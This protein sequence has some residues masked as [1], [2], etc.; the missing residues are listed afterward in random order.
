MAKANKIDSNVTGLRYAEEVSLGVLPASPVWKPLEPNSYN[1]FGGQITT[2]ARNPINP[3]RQRKKGVVTDLDASGGFNSDLT[4]E[5][6]QDILQ[7]FFFASLRRKGEMEYFTFSKNFVATPATD[8]LAIT[9]HGLKT[10]QGPLQASSTTTLPAGLAA[11]TDYWP[12]VV[13]DDNIKLATSYANA[14]AGTAIDIT[15]AGTGTHTLASVAGV[16]A[17]DDSFEVSDPSKFKAN[18]LVR[19]TGFATE[20]NNGIHLVSAVTG[21]LV[22]VGTALTDEVGPAGAK[23][24]VIG[25]QG[26]SGDLSIDASGSFP[27]L[28]SV[29]LD[30]TTLGLIPGEWVFVGGDLAAEAFDETENNGLKRIRSIAANRIEFDKS[31][32][33][34]TTDAGAGKTIRLYFGRVLKNELGSDVIRRSYNIE[35]TLGAPETSLPNQIQAEYLVGAVPSEI[36]INVP[37]ANKLTL[38]VSFMATDNEQRE[39][40]EGLK[41]GSRPAIVEADAFN[42]SSDFVRLKMS[43]V[44]ADEAPVALFAFLTELTITINNNLTPNKAVAVL[45]AFDVTA[46]TFQVGGNVTAYFSDIAA[47]KAVR[48]NADVTIDMALVKANSGMVIDIPLVALGDGRL[49]VQQDQAIQL[50]LSMDAAT[51]AKI[52]PDLDYTAMWVFFDYLPDLAG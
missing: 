23:L 5:N 44:E 18:S 37:Q 26:A 36:S 8:Q 20:A 21:N 16:T 40:A 1:D 38:D 30:F 48:E 3:S 42:T 24:V 50:P 33:A 12:I 34:M 43:K 15:D 7:G 45:G 27:A 29:A 13:D 14:I 46:G 28:V 35:R 9:S 31:A 19:S 22:A 52:D 47:V 17:V 51:A 25:H 32:L 10:G 49:N 41:A 2:V 6:M 11:A 4:Q 39:A